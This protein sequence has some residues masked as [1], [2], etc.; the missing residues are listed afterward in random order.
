MQFFFLRIMMPV[1]FLLF[2]TRRRRWSALAI[3]TPLLMLVTVA[4]LVFAAANS[5]RSRFDMLQE[6][7]TVAEA[8]D[9]VG[10]DLGKDFSFAYLVGDKMSVDY[11]YENTNGFF[12]VERYHVSFLDGRLSDKE[13]IKL[14]PKEFWFTTVYNIRK[15]LRF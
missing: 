13:S 8:S 1:V 4:C 11:F 3:L 15:L 7:M 5:I 14:T 9:V 6:G 2:G 10:K 12:T